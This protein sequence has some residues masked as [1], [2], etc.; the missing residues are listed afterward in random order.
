MKKF[1]SA[2]VVVLFGAFLVLA[3]TYSK[4]IPGKNSSSSDNW[5]VSEGEKAVYLSDYN[6]EDLVELGDYKNLL[7]DVEYT[8]VTEEYIIK[9]IEETMTSYPDYR[10]TDKV[11]IE[12]GD[13][14]NIDYVGSKG[15]V[16]FEG[17]TAEGYNLTIG[18][19]AFIDGFEEGLIGV[20]VGSTVT[21]NLTFPE[22][23]DSEELAGQAV[24]FEVTVNAI[25]EAITYTY[26]EM[27]DD[28]IYNNTGYESKQELFDYVNE[29]YTSNSETDKASNARQ[30]V[31]DAAIGASV[32]DVPDELLNYRVNKYLASLKESLEASGY[33]V[34]EYIESYYNE[35]EDEFYQE[36]YDMMFDSLQQQILLSLIAEKE[37]ITIDED[38]YAEYVQSFVNYYGYEDASQLYEDYSED[39]I[40]TAYICNDVVDYL[41]EI[42]T[43]NYIPVYEEED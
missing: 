33:D 26:D 18:S 34:A 23:Y 24:T 14:V 6:L 28:Y 16:P 9:A 3:A 39:E 10:K 30:M 29:Y 31:I 27:T 41:M 13:V 37:G 25:M 22:D 5:D 38:G 11:L 43:F 20:K 42:A 40:R 2:F 15:G 12:N 32:V 1:V 17:G 35:T 36:V 21:L 8:A 19:G 4:D 7:V